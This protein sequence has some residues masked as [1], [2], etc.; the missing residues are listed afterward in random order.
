MIVSNPWDLAFSSSGKKAFV[1]LAS[2]EDI[3]V[4]NIA[5]SMGTAKKKRHRKR[6]KR[7]GTGAKVTQIFRAYP[8]NTNPRAILIHPKNNNIYVQNASRLDMT[9]LSSG[10]EHPFARLK[11]KKDFFS[12]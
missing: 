5:R 2:S 1:T 7:S 9:L 3:M 12:N 4:L 11:L 6:A 10:G 8:N